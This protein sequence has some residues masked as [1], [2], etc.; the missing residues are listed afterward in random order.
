MVDVFSIQSSYKIGHT[1][2]VKEGTE[3]LKRAV[4]G[5]N[6]GEWLYILNI[7]NKIQNQHLYVSFG[8]WEME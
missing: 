7:T 3:V 4:D 6:V 2:T 1:L 5:G 8:N